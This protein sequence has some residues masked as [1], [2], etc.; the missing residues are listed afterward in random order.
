[1]HR[2]DRS[3]GSPTLRSSDG[4]S[5]VFFVLLALRFDWIAAQET[6]CSANRNGSKSDNEMRDLQ[7][8]LSSYLLNT[9]E[10][11]LYKPNILDNE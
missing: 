1:M 7:R 10:L 2:C 5:L 9:S 11:H 8:F 3:Q 6:F 4:H